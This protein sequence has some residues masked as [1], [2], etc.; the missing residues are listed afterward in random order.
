MEALM[1]DPRF[2][3]LFS[4][5]EREAARERLVAYGYEVP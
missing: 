1:I 2:E 3:P 5:E 4:E